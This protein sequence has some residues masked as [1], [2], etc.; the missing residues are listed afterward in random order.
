MSSCSYMSQSIAQSLKSL[1][2][3]IVSCGPSTRFLNIS[4]GWSGSTTAAASRAPLLLLTSV[5]RVVADVLDV[6][7]VLVLFESHG[8]GGGGGCTFPRNEIQKR[9]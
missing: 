7:E 1:V 8:E 4:M 2:F 6:F 5:A 9:C 3:S